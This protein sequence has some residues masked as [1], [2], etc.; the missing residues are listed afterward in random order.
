MNYNLTITPKPGNHQDFKY[1]LS[2][3]NTSQT[4]LGS[5]STHY[6]N[7]TEV[8]FALDRAG[9]PELVRNAG[10]ELELGRQFSNVMEISDYQ[11]GIMLKRS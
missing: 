6:S 3:T 4:T 7:L 8:K 5:R 9:W 10:K 1:I 11:A 2:I